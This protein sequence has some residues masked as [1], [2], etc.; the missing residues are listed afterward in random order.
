MFFIYLA[1]AY[2]DFYYSDGSILEQ[3]LFT[4][5]LPSQRTVEF[6]VGNFLLALGL[7]LLFFEIFKST[8]TN[9]SAVIEH[10]LSALVFIVYV[11]FF[12]YSSLCDSPV[13]FILTLMTL[14]DV[15]T[16]IIIGI[17]AARRDVGLN[18]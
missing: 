10:V 7:I 17:A 14:L 6:T 11:L 8:Y 9:T 5:P 4:L 18:N 15:L 16:G 2:Y 12:F 3:V 13:F 1:L